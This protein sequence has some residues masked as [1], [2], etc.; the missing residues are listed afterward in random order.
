MTAMIYVDLAH[1]HPVI[2]GVWHFAALQRMPQSGEPVRMMCGVS[3]V[4]AYERIENRVSAGHNNGPPTACRKCDE[5]V[6]RQK[7]IPRRSLARR[8][9]R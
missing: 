4:A 3:A 9:D 8:E 6:R 7:G 2:D 1:V 5:I